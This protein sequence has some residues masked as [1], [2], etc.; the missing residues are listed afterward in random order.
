MAAADLLVVRFV[1]EVEALD[2]F[3]PDFGPFLALPS[4]FSKM[5]SKLWYC[6]GVFLSADE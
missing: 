6:V 5:Y 2:V 3:E 1:G 4:S